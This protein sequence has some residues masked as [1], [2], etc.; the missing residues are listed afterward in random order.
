M[1]QNWAKAQWLSAAPKEQPSENE[2]EVE[3]YNNDRINY[4]ET[5]DMQ[6]HFSF[7][8]PKP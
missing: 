8:F 4:L 3:V 2:N 5:I 7:D 1:T 6:T